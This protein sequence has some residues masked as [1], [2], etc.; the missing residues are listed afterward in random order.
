MSS[1]RKADSDLSSVSSGLSSV[2]DAEASTAN[3]KSSKT[4]KLKSIKPAAA[5]KTK[6]Y[7]AAPAK[8]KKATTTKTSAGADSGRPEKAAAKPK[9]NGK[10]KAKAVV[11]EIQRVEKRQRTYGLQSQDLIEYPEDE[12][13]KS[14]YVAVSS[15]LY[16]I[17]F[18]F[19]C[20]WQVPY[21]WAFIVKFCKEAIKGLGVVDE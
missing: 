14:E 2:P 12:D 9:A 11:E 19:L 5:K 10:G 17:S 21:V 16:G 18:G 15:R 4:S 6:V 3:G 20:S 13:I 7:T 8:A 1:R